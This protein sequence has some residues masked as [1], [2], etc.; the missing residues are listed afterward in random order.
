MTKVVSFLARLGFWPFVMLF[1]ILATILAE[2]AVMA[3]SYWLTGSFFDKM[4]LTAGFIVPI[5][6]GLFM[7]SLVA[8]LIRYLVTVQENL[9]SAEKGLKNSNM[10]LKEAQDIAHLGFWEFDLEK[11]RLF[12]SD[13]VYRIFGLQPQEFEATFEGFLNY[14]HPEDRDA[15]ANEY[16]QSVQE[17]RSYHLVHRIIPKNGSVRYVEEHCEHSYNKEGKPVRSIGTV[18]DITERI[19]DQNKLQRLFDL[20]KNI[21][22]QTDGQVI[23]KANYSFLHFFGYAT[24]EDFLKEHGCICD[25]F[26]EDERFFHRGKLPEGNED[27]VEVL[28]TLPKKE[29][30]VS[31]LNTH[32]HPYAFSVSINHF[33]DDDF[34]VSFTDIS[35]TM[36]EQFSLEERVS[37]DH[38]TGAYSRGFFD[39]NIGDFI[40]NAEKRNRHLGLIMMDIDHFKNV[41]DTFGHDIGDR[42]LKHLVSTV[43]YSI[44]SGDLLIRWGG[45]EF[46]LII[47]TES[48]ETLRRMAE[49]V[50]QRV[51]SELFEI[52]GKVTCSFGMTLH[53]PDESIDQTLKRA[54]IAL[55]EA[56]ESGRNKVVQ[57]KNQIY[58]Y[59]R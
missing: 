35:E 6:V 1:T 52:V 20:Q 57:A 47:E 16:R 13:E 46:L 53:T 43:K 11:D 12:W 22:I 18:Y 49:H 38:L 10:L 42:V 45:E 59:G 37:R 24:L 36:S 54:D 31:L 58:V 40:E 27:W 14:V 28:Q 29:R 23:K 3:V 56:K 34:I 8:Y 39:E 41:N 26:V 51:E 50:R 44:R 32:G 30:V 9:K 5:F 33:D 7:F 25:L 19:A 2:T 4:L 15:L 21:I 17:K 48:V 55:Y